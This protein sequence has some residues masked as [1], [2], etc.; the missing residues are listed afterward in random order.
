MECQ[1]NRSVMRG[2]ADTGMVSGS[3]ELRLFSERWLPDCS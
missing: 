3:H 1:S 2:G